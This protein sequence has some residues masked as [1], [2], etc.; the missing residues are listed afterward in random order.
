MKSIEY[1]EIFIEKYSRPLKNTLTIFDKTI[2]NDET[3]HL[4]IGKCI[5]CEIVSLIIDDYVERTN[6]F[7]IY[8]NFKCNDLIVYWDN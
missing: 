6:K 3:G 4:I 2:K 1:G 8:K 5:V 7:S